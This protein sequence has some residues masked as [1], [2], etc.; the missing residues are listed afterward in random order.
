MLI[1]ALR[2]KRVYIGAF[3]SNNVIITTK[4]E[5]IIK[6]QKKYMPREIPKLGNDVQN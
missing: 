3:L 5:A 2:Y 6:L 4:N 1:K